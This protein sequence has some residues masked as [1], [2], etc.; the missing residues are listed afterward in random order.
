MKMLEI[1]KGMKKGTK[2]ILCLL[3]LGLIGAIFFDDSS[4]VESDAESAKIEEVVEI[5]KEP[6]LTNEELFSKLEGYATLYNNH[7]KGFVE[8]ADTNDSVEMKKLF[9]ETSSASEATFG[10]LSDTKKEYNPDTNE[11]K[12]IDE[13]QTAF[14]SL[15]DA[16]KAGINYIEKNEEKYLSKYEDN[17]D[18]ANIFIERY[19]EAKSNIEKQ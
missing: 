11:Y 3:V 8:V 2:I 14:N 15:K 7:L 4:E 6:S 17:I 12:T 9:E 18:Q 1:I 16:C 19:N 5:S 10:L 13:L